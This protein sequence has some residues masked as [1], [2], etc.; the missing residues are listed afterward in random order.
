MFYVLQVDKIM[1]RTYERTPGLRAYKDYYHSRMSEA[2]EAEMSK[3]RAVE[4][5]S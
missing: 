4:T 5:Y 1:V 3:K 2:V